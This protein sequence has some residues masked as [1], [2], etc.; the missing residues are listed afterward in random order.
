MLLPGV[1]GISIASDALFSV[2]P[3]IRRYADNGVLKFLRTLPPRTV[4]HFGG[5]VANRVLLMSVS[6][7][8]LCGVATLGFGVPV[9]GTTVLTYLL[10]VGLGG[11]AFSVIGLTAAFASDTVS[12]RGL[13]NLLYLPMLFVSGAF[14][15]ISILPDGLQTVA[16][17]LPLTHLV[18]FLKGQSA[19]GSLLVGWG[20]LFTAA[21]YAVFRHR[22][23]KR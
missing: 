16:Y 6:V 14:Y 21:A 2:G 19:Y 15:P 18:E 23:A 7:F 9:T 1:I 5:T 10:G 3:V 13:L 4:A 8:L 11:W 22:Q 20:L 12:P 17:L